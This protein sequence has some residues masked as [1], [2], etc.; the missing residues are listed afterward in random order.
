MRHSLFR[1]ILRAAAF[2]AGLAA[3]TASTAAPVQS[4]RFSG[5]L[6]MAW[7]DPRPGAPGGGMRFSVTLP[8][9]AVYPL[10]VSPAQQGAAIAGFGRHV[11]IRGRLTTDAQGRKAIAAE[12]IDASAVGG[13]QKRAAAETRKVL[14]ILLKSRGDSQEPH[15]K[16]F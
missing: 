11:V 10:V 3:L 2:A 1:N 13:A 16:G 14:F 5:T 12:R 8:D 4:S 6:T 9:G 15:A 7:G